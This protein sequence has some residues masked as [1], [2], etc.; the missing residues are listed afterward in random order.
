M[1]PLLRTLGIEDISAARLG[2]TRRYRF[3]R[4]TTA[5]RLTGKLL[6]F[7]YERSD[8][9]GPP[10]YNCTYVDT[11]ALFRT[12]RGRYVVYYILHHLECDDMDGLYEYVKVVEDFPALELFVSQMHYANSAH[13]HPE[14][15]KE[16]ARQDGQPA[17]T[18]AGDDEA[19]PAIA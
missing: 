13:F 2:R 17:Q 12:R 10:C 6:A 1:L 7:Y 4:G 5:I 15:I 19:A 18:H 16:A 14:L 11:V 3:R 9:S 8:E